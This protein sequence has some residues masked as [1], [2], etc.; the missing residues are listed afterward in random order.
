M[1]KYPNTKITNSEY[2][3]EQVGLKADAKTARRSD[4]VF[5]KGEHLLLY[6]QHTFKSKAFSM[7]N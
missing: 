6:G 7:S 2:K 4:Q 5:Q 3:A 1:E